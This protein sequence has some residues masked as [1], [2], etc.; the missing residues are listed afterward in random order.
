VSLALLNKNPIKA[1]GNVEAWLGS[2]ESTMMSSLRRLAKQGMATYPEEPRTEWV[3]QQPAQ[4]VIAVSQVYW[5]AAVE[6]QL[7][8]HTPQ[9]G[10]SSFHQVR[11]LH[12]Q[13]TACCCHVASVCCTG[14]L[15]AQYMH[16]AA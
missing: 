8:G 9:H 15:Q 11:N 13:L 10:L 16:N 2:V 1:R 7:R 5:C 14:V 6:E 12:D 4:L 3:L